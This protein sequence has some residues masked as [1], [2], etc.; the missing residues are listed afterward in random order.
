M[1]CN[2]IMEKAENLINNPSNQEFSDELTIQ[3]NCL[4][5]IL[6][7]KFQMLRPT[8]VLRDST[9]ICERLASLK[10]LSN[11]EYLGF[12]SPVK[13]EID[14]Y[15]FACF[16]RTRGIKI[17]YPRFNKTLRA[18]EMGAVHNLDL[19]FNPGYLG[20][21]EPKLSNP[22]A[23]REIVLQRMTW[24]VPGLG[25]DSKGGRLGRGSGYYD[26]LLEKTNGRKFG[27]AYDWQIENDIPIGK[28]DICMDYIVTESRTLVCS[29]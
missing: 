17:Y 27:I 8:K 23:E 12:F 7:K 14:L 13:N 6:V 5:K 29:G 10:E 4:R 11:T 1:N 24:L 9:T 28:K 21:P 20:I 16:S 2:P 18:Y 26:T 19:D 15:S 22:S 25:F 3:K